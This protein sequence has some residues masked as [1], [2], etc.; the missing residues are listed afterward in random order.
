[1]IIYSSLDV[2]GVILP[3]GI[4]VLLYDSL[5]DLITLYV[6]RYFVGDHV[7]YSHGSFE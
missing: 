3:F 2:P 6:F 7:I 1:M 4:V 5:S